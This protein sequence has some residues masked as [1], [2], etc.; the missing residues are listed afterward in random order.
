MIA[1]ALFNFQVGTLY[2]SLKSFCPQA[3]NPRELTL[4]KGEVVYVRRRV[5]ANWFEGEREDGAGIFPVNYVKIIYGGAVE[6][7]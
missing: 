5:D 2:L 6:E 1:R 3:M 4:K 7:G